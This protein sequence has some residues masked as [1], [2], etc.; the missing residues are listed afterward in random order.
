MR[1]T[2]NRQVSGRIGGIVSC[3]IWVSQCLKLYTFVGI[4]V[5]MRD[6]VYAFPQAKSW[7][8]LPISVGGANRNAKVLF[9]HEN[10]N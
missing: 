3:N 1:V 2:H 8:K 5:C 9:L 7:D 6:C 4:N 10:N